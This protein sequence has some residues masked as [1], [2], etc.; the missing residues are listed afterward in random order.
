MA[1]LPQNIQK[2]ETIEIVGCFGLYITNGYPG[3]LLIISILS[4]KR[5]NCVEDKCVDQYL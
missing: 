5:G 3:L 2:Y 4:K 1:M